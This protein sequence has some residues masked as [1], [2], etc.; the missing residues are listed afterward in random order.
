MPPK[1]NPL[2]LNKLQ[3]KTLTL[4]QELAKTGTEQDDGAVLV[5]GFPAPHGDH[6]HIGEG[7]TY[8]RDATG[9]RNEVVFRALEKKGMIVSQFPM[10][11]LVTADGIDYDT[12]MRDRIIFTGNSD[13]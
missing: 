10:A 4:L 6:F 7:V 3:L 9:L 5:S 12:G 2:K 11:A 13:D 1:R 8:K